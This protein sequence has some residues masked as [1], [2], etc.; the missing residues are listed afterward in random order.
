MSKYWSNGS[1]ANTVGIDID[2]RRAFDRDP[3]SIITSLPV[4]KSTA[5]HLNGIG[6]RSKFFLNSYLYVS[7][8]KRREIF[9]P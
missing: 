7:E 2:A 1:G 8:E 3:F 9:C 4:I 6:S 5:T